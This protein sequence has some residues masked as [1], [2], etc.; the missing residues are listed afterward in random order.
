MI[1]NFTDPPRAAP[2]GPKSDIATG[3]LVGVRRFG[4]GAGADFRA[5]LDG[6]TMT[7]TSSPSEQPLAETIDRAPDGNPAPVGGNILPELDPI[8]QVMSIPL[9]A[10]DPPA[11]TAVEVGPKLAALSRSSQ[12]VD[13]STVP[14]PLQ[15][16]PMAQMANSLDEPTARETSIHGEAAGAE[17]PSFVDARS[18]Q[19]SKSTPQLTG[20]NAF[21]AKKPQAAEASG[22]ADLK[23]TTRPI[24]MT[25]P[26]VDPPEASLSKA[27][28]M[29]DASQPLAGRF[30]RSPAAPPPAKLT[31]ASA[32]QAQAQSHEQVDPQP[33]RRATRLAPSLLPIEARSKPST[34]DAPTVQRTTA[35]PAPSPTAPAPSSPLPGSPSQPTSATTDPVANARLAPQIESTIEQLVQTRENGRLA[36]PEMTL[37]HQQFGAVTVRLEAVGNDL[38]AT[39]AARD[40]AFAPAVHAALAERAI[41][42]IAESASG[43]GSRGSD[44]GHGNGSSS[45]GG[46]N[47]NGGAWSGPGGGS[48]Q[49]YGSSTGSGQASQQPYAGQSERDEAEPALRTD[50]APGDMHE[51]RSRGLFA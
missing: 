48:D 27:I 11:V 23:A 39:L 16:M 1:P 19:A 50:P 10:Q 33:D 29:A 35:E 45:G 28:P 30:A 43:S 13:A 36:Q 44:Q 18:G 25:P 49:R 4:D 17:T 6:E 26:D 31:A 7:D 9:A 8:D 14:V 15:T 37:R 34:I 51:D 46:S 41:A 40:P 38:R 12:P 5:L 2:T 3:G 24:A 20:L 47:T 32:S 21:L 42:P 22:N